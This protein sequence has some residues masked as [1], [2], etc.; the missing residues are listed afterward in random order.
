MRAAGVAGVVGA[1]GDL[2]VIQH[3]LG[4]LGLAR[5][6]RLGHV[7]HGPVHGLVVARRG[8]EEVRHRDLVVVVDAVVMEER[9]TRCLQHADAL[10]LA[11]SGDHESIFVNEDGQID[12][13]TYYRDGRVTRVE[14]DAS[15]NG[16]RDH[17]AHYDDGRL[18]REEKDGD[19]DG[20]P[21]LITHYDASE[22]VQRVEEDANGD[23]ELDVVSHYEAGR[24]KSRE[25]LDAAVL[26][27]AHR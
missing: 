17:I 8:D 3:P 12:T 22:R 15:G 6:V 18:L 4:D 10:F 26:E 16:F 9:A 14:R 27:G 24:L 1:D 5:D 20:I 11:R 23:G 13:W 21:D 25:I 7:G 2:H 19:G